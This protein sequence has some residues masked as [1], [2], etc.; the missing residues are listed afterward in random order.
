MVVDAEDLAA[1][2]TVEALV[3]AEEEAVEASAEASAVVPEDLLLARETGF[4]TGI[5]FFFQDLVFAAPQPK[6]GQDMVTN[7]VFHC[8][9]YHSLSLCP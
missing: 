2:V 9:I 3:V 7:C 1:A 8:M 6:T 4:V 5:V